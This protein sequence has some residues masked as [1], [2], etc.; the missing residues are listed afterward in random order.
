[1]A[2]YAHSH[3][4]SKLAGPGDARPTALQIIAD[5]NLT[6]KLTDK[7]YVVT[8]VSNGIGVETLRALH[9]TGAHIYGTARDVSKGQK[10][11]DEILAS[12]PNGGKITLIHMVLDDLSSVRKGASEILTKSNN[13]LNGLITNA[14]IMAVPE[15]R[16]A[17][18]FES[19]FGVDHLAHFLL[20]QLLRQALLDA[21]TSDFPSRVVSVSSTGHKFSSVQFSDIN[22]ENEKYDEWKA[23]GQAKTANI[24]FANAL[25]RR[26]ASKN[27]HSTSL[28]PGGILTGLGWNVSPEVFKTFD[29][30]AMR[31]YFKNAEQG[32]A[33]QVYAAV[34]AEWKGKGGR[35]L[36]DCVE[37]KPFGTAGIED[38]MVDDGY[39]AWAYDEEGEERLWKESLKMVGLEGEE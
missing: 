3:L 2:Q 7:S 26:Y 33:T 11:V 13:R 1:M 6:N 21:A 18:G 38:P 31:R 29:T 15:G 9:S 12:N 34:S 8:G 20:F 25:E 28:H 32:A 35:Y 27:L 14:G 23:Y 19:Q 10:V 36:S 30:P 16:T 5:E 17:D 4:R 22:F 24:W 37:Q 39:A